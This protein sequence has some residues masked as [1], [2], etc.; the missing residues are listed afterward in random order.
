MDDKSSKLLTADDLPTFFDIV[1]ENNSE[2][3][4]QVEYSAKDSPG[5]NDGITATWSSEG[6]YKQNFA[7]QT[8]FNKMNATDVRKLTW[9]SNK[10]YVQTMTDSP[11]PIDVRK[12]LVTNRDVVVLRK[13]EAVF[14]QIEALYHTDPA[15]ALTKLNTWMKTYRDPGYSFT[16]TG[17]ALLTEILM[18]KDIE[19]FLEGF[20]YTDLKR[21][22]VGI[23]NPQTGVVIAANALQMK[24]LPIP[25]SETNANPNIV[26][27]PGY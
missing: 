24:A 2:T 5:A 10:G 22:G 7:T 21:N 17:S 18:Q 3:L 6:R 9:Y 19:F 13:T 20:R 4:F 26:Q 23:S 1:G 25:R 8:F 15:M 14:N 27:F 12:Y 16:G 11:K